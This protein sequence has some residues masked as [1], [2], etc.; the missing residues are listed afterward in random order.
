VIDDGE[1]FDKK[2]FSYVF[3]ADNESSMNFQLFQLFDFL[4]DE[5]DKEND[6][7]C[8]ENRIVIGKSH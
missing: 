8:I 7:L 1:T 4:S 3:Y 6:D 5:G 2:S